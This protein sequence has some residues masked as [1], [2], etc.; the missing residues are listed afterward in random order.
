MG[1]SFMGKTVSFTLPTA[2]PEGTPGHL[3]ARIERALET[4]EPEGRQSSAATINAEFSWVD[5]GNK[6][7]SHAKEI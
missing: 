5:V 2:P 7:N 6:M 3:L 4:A 1:E